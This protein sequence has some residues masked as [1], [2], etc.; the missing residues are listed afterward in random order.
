MPVET[1]PQLMLDRKVS[2]RTAESGA[3][4]A[5]TGRALV[6]AREVRRHGQ[7]S[8]IRRRAGIVRSTTVS[9]AFSA[10][11]VK[12]RSMPNRTGDGGIETCA[13]VGPPPHNGLGFRVVWKTWIGRVGGVTPCTNSTPSPG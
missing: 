2:G 13:R 6:G 8:Q 10:A 7:G 11:H 3:G 4:E 9:G 1:I 5:D 12:S